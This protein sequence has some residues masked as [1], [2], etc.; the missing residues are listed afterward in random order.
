M[1]VSR[2][3][4][5]YRIRRVLIFTCRY[6]IAYIYY[7]ALRYTYKNI[8]PDVTGNPWRS[9]SSDTDDIRRHNNFWAFL[10]PKKRINILVFSSRKHVSRRRPD[11]LIYCVLFASQLVLY[12]SNLTY[13]KS[14]CFFPHT[15][16]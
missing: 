4:L 13:N 15:F 14:Y 16:E 5:Q 10:S 1:K 2:T 3:T 7:M 6:L 11:I 12:I 9:M 8:C